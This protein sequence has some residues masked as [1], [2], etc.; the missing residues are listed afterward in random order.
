MET[1][2]KAYMINT[3]VLTLDGNSEIGA[4][5]ASKLRNLICQGICLTAVEEPKKRERIR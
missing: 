5:A 1:M 4:H 2:E 3:M